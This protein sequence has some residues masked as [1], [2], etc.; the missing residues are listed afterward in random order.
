[1]ITI[2]SLDFPNKVYPDQKFSIEVNFV[3]RETGG[4]AKAKLFWQGEEKKASSDLWV[5]TANQLNK[6][7]LSDITLAPSSMPLDF[8]VAMFWGTLGGGEVKQESRQIKIQVVEIK[9]S[10]DHM[11]KSVNADQSFVLQCSV[12]NDGNDKTYNVTGEITNYDGFSP[13]GVLQKPIGT[14]DPS[15]SKSIAFDLSCPFTIWGGI[16]EATLTLRYQDWQSR[17]YETQH[18][19]SIK[20][21][22]PQAIY[23]KVF[24]LII[25]WAIILIVL[26]VF[27][28]WKAKKV[29]LWPL[30]ARR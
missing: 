2:T 5:W 23:E 11:P 26:L 15:S 12:K 28:I 17:K 9:L 10:V 27:V 4:W 24:T 3:C 13:K 29:T 18:K 8:E 19:L 22:I 21:D 16:W 14:L 25:P 1:M 20:V 7:V 6:V 30:T